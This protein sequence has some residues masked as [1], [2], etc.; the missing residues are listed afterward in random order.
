MTIHWYPGHMHKANKEMAELLPQVDIVIE[1]LD[2]RLPASSSNPKIAELR[3]EKP[4]IKILSKS[5]LADPHVTKL[6]QTHF[7]Q[8][9]NIKT[10]LTTLSQTDKAQRVV[11]LCK[12]MVPNK[13]N[14]I[15]TMVVM[16]T[17]IPNVGKSTLIN[18]LAGRIVAKTG[19]EPA[20]TKGQQRIKLDNGI[21]LIDTPGILWPKIYNEQSSYRLATTGAIKDTAINHEDIAFYAAEFLRAHYPQRLKERFELTELPESELEILELIGA[22]RGGLRAGGHVDLDKVSTILLNEVRSGKL[23]RLSFE[24]PEVIAEENILV[25]ELMAAREAKGPKRKKRKKKR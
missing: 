16:I 9:D 19:N 24:T 5:D 8:D 21:T 10:L 2:A 13:A 3:S 1:L 18:A 22:R 17:G 4:S 12:K 20:I 7:E 15:R 11:E 14:G 6:W 25:A 23:G